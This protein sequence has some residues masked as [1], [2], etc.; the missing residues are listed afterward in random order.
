MG[1]VT[2]ALIAGAANLATGA[3]S[4]KGQ[5]DANA[6]NLAIA[7]E[8]MKFQERMSSTAYQR[9][10]ADLEKAGLNRILALGS[11][12]SS[13]AG[14]SATMQNPSA[15]LAAGVERATATALA[16]RRTGQELK[17]MA[18]AETKIKADSKY[19][20][21]QRLESLA[22][23]ALIMEQKKALGGAAET[24]DLIG[25]AISAGKRSLTENIELQSLWDQAKRDA[26]SAYEWGKEK[27]SRPKREKTKTFYEWSEKDKSLSLRQFNAWE[28]TPEGRRAK[29]RYNQY[30]KGLNR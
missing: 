9:S 12:A 17:N 15:E 29:A 5:R 21:Q 30:L 20:N 10:A 25:N 8:Q 7:R 22:R 27:L 26:S 4:A 23:T 13:P 14:A 16:Y 19:V 2:A 18:A 11:P 24:G 3:M 6:K 1:L 28:K